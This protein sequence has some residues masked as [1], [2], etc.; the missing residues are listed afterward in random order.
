[1]MRRH[2]TRLSQE[3]DDPEDDQ[4]QRTASHDYPELGSVL[5]DRPDPGRQITVVGM[6]RQGDAYGTEQDPRAHEYNGGEQDLGM[7]WAE[8]GQQQWAED[9]LG[10][11]EEAPPPLYDPDMSP[12]MARLAQIEEARQFV[13]AHPLARHQMAR[14]ATDING[15]HIDD[16][17]DAPE[18]GLAHRAADPNSYD[19]RSTEGDGDPMWDDALPKSQHGDKNAENGATVGMYPEGIGSGSGPS[20]PV[21]AFVAAAEWEQNPDLMD[22]HG[23][24]TD[25]AGLLRHMREAHGMPEG[26]PLESEGDRSLRMIH[27]VR[28]SRGDRHA[29]Y[30]PDDDGYA[31]D[32]QREYGRTEAPYEDEPGQDSAT[33]HAHNGPIDPVFGARTAAMSR[34]EFEDLRRHME[35]QHGEPYPYNGADEFQRKPLAEDHAYAHM[36][37][38]PGHAHPGDYEFDPYWDENDTAG[39]THE[40]TGLRHEARVPWTG[41]ERGTLHRWQEEPTATWGDFVPS[42]EFPMLKPGEHVSHE[43]QGEG[44]GPVEG[45]A[46]RMGEDHM[47]EAHGWDDEQFERARRDATSLRRVHDALHAAG[48]AGH[49]HQVTPDVM[50]GDARE[51]SLANMFGHDLAITPKMRAMTR[52]RAGGSS[53]Q[54]FGTTVEPR[55]VTDPAHWQQAD[56]ARF[57][58]M[59]SALNVHV[60]IDGKELEQPHEHDD[61][62]NSLDH[63]ED[64]PQ[65]N[66]QDKGPDK[67]G[68][69]IKSP[70]VDDGDSLDNPLDN[71]QDNPQESP[72]AGSQDFGDPDQWPQ[73]GADVNERSRAYTQGSG[74]GK[75]T[76]GAPFSPSDGDSGGGGDQDGEDP[77]DSG[78]DDE[79]TPFSK[80]GA[81]AMFTAA[82]GSPSYR[83]H[84]TAT[85]NDVVEKARRIRSEGHVR[86]VHASAGMVIGE[87][88]GDHD[89][90]EAGIQRPVG[91]KLAIAHWA[92]GCP[93]ASFHQSRKVAS[94]FSGRPCSHVMAL[95]FEAQA[96]GMFGRSFGEDSAAPSWAPP[97]VVVKSWPPYEGDPHAGK[98]REEWRAPVARRAS[99]ANDPGAPAHRATATL[100]RAG[101]DPAE[102]GALRMMA[103]LR[104]TADQANAPWGG[105][106]VSK[107]P[108]QKPY[109]ATSPPNLDQDPGSY[110]PLAGPDPANWGGIDDSSAMQMPLTNTAS[111]HRSGDPGSHYLN[112]AGEAREQASRTRRDWIVVPHASAVQLRGGESTLL[113]THQLSHGNGRAHLR[114]TPEG[115]WSDYRPEGGYQRMDS[116]PAW[117]HF[118]DAAAYN[119]RIGSPQEAQ[120]GSGP[121]GR[122]YEYDPRY[123]QYDHL[124]QPSEEGIDNDTAATYH[125]HE[126][127]IDPVFGSRTAQH[128]VLVPGAPHPVPGDLHWP[129]MNG[130]QAEDQGTFG[131]TDHASTAGPSTAMD[132][133]DPNGIRMEEARRGTDSEGHEVEF[134]PLDGWQHLDGSVSHDDGSVVTDH[135]VHAE[136]RDHPEPALPSTT[137]D[138]EIEATA[139]ADG[140]IG[141]GSAGTGMGQG[142]ADD[143]ASLGEF[144]A[145]M[146]DLARETWPQAQQ[147]SPVGQEPGMGSQDE[148][149]SPD[150]QSIQTIGN[151]QWSGGGIDDGPGA[152]PAG[153]PQGSIDDIVASF[154]RSAAAR[155]YNADRATVLAADGDIAAAAR[156]YLSKTA[157]VLPKAEAEELIREGAGSRA[158][159]LDLLRLEGTH[160]EDLGDERGDEVEDDLVWA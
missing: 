15:A 38:D 94:R 16:H 160:Y 36:Y 121:G 68:P 104:A 33:Y 59:M 114:V 87:V 120:A 58:R 3:H 152:V 140:T 45:S 29:D 128:Q 145:S 151:Q 132:P 112:A 105:D 135:P 97:T 149:L 106:N 10:P 63:D 90:Y 81:L 50:P 102:V 4:G 96:R 20:V 142:A 37:A 116:H 67:T 118:Y 147:P 122:E 99:L 141:G 21:G 35:E 48:L 66:P 49:E 42:S 88:R 93:W 78:S 17:G 60:R 28:H 130:W 18:H 62:G 158:R 46:D 137:G 103:G 40:F 83:W 144:G 89:T 76:R 126:G 159:N 154:Q 113:A 8:P 9:H 70:Q 65:D 77:N 14:R 139:A 108:P 32:P 156:Q 26:H 100:L 73:A 86:I 52:D 134:D 57:R 127:P 91:K 129:S 30:V 107:T 148:Y 61:A 39:H 95:Q 138:D 84:F 124:R 51:Q 75:V 41:K 2:S 71:S 110:G 34:E 31:Y 115:Q 43:D 157:D 133:R 7:N 44:I 23:H 150:D 119:A 101:E 74:D 125:A 82:A 25:R 1:M 22:V 123:R 143:T 69:E 11:Q 131:Y 64:G 56:P 47:R 12:V 19:G 155:G 80:D 24:M 55:P 146:G 72:Q 54:E 136:L 98:W 6:R 92:C 5:E 79:D 117:H 85:W 109:G 53:R 111:V 153:E 13:G 27:T